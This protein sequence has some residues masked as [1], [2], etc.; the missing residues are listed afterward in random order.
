MAKTD[1]RIE[2]IGSAILTQAET[3]AKELIEK[4]NEIHEKEISQAESEIVDGMFSE[5]Q[6]KAARIRTDSVKTA[7]VEQLKAH[8]ELL[9]YRDKKTEAVLENV[10]ARL[11]EYTKTP[12]YREK[13]LA[14]AEAARDSYDHSESVILVCEDDLDLAKAINEKLG[15][16]ARIETSAGIKIGG[17]KIKNLKA[18]ILIDETMDERLEENRIWFLQN[19][20]FKIM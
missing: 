11:V 18:H 4:A 1:D 7:A 14:Y 9:A 13:A 15:G 6:A 16:K 17:F 12:E 5:I 2:L 19:C 3:E 10:K 20:G 8:R